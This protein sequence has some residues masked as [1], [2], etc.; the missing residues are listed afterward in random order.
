RAGRL[1]AALRRSGISTAMYP[2]D[3]AAAASGVD[4]VVGARS[5]VWATAPDLGS[6]VVVDE[7]DDTLQEERAPTWHAR[8]VAIERA[9]RLAIP[10][11]LTSPVA[12]ITAREWAGDNVV[13]VGTPPRWPR[14]QVVDRNADEQWASSLV[15][16]ALIELLRDKSKRVVCVLNVKG[17]ARAVV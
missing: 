14:V 13:A 6:I 17:R 1:A 4:V 9:R 16:S 15:T 11:V 8:D 10:C 3:W 2:E 7:H 12:T 5:A